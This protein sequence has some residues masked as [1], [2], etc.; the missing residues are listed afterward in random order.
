MGGRGS[1]GREIRKGWGGRGS[2]GM[3]RGKGFMKKKMRNCSAAS[4][5][6]PFPLMPSPWNMVKLICCA[7]WENGK[8]QK[9]R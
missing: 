4:A 8:K 9:R 5:H 3:G 7:V 2:R 6:P 1:R